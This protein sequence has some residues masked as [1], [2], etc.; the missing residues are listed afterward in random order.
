[1][2]RGR[3]D[4]WRRVHEAGGFDP[5]LFAFPDDHSRAVRS[6]RWAYHGDVARMAA[7]FRPARFTSPVEE[8]SRAKA[9]GAVGIVR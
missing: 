8:V 2:W 5:H 4:R 9:P 3:L 1:M 6:A 7:A